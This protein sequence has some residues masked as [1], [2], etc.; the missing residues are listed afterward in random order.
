MTV[1][2]RLGFV[3]L[4]ASIGL[5]ACAEE[6]PPAQPAESAAVKDEMAAPW[7]E[8]GNVAVA[9][10]HAAPQPAAAALAAQ[11]APAAEAPAEA[12]ATE[13][14]PADTPSAPAA[15]DKKVAKA[16]AGPAR[17]DVASAGTA[18]FLIDAPLE[19]IKGRWNR[20]GGRLNIDF[21]D[22]NA[23]RGEVTMDLSTLKTT[24]FGNPGKDGRQTGHALNWMEIGPDVTPELRK[25]NMT[26]RFVIESVSGAT[27]ASGT[28]K[29]AA[30][31]KLT[32]HG[33]TL[34]KTVNLVVTI[35]GQKDAP[36]SVRIKTA[37][38]MRVSLKGHDVKP[39]DLAG[40]FLAGALE[41]VGEKVTDS[42]QVMIDV[43]AT[44]AGG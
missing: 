14:E 18:T 23:T 12:A 39:R 29:V 1:I 16:P 44:R 25:K 27:G 33:I 21:S 2:D 4:A 26:A 43:T 36:T 15:A 3:L 40:R 34:P 6:A 24:T 8:P 32:L 17:F 37:S 13:P 10:P 31:G 22:L 9:T 41:R 20:F 5:I 7:E 30:K 28:Q 38:P 42:T 11:T 35:E 19:K